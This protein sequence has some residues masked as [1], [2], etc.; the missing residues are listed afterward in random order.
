[1]QQNDL[2]NLIP[3]KI[4]SM[5][6]VNITSNNTSVTKDR[7]CFSIIIKTEGKTVYISDNKKY[8][9]DPN[10]IVFIPKGSSYKWSCIERGECIIIDFDSNTTCEN[11]KIQSFSIKNCSEF[12]KAFKKAE[13][14]WLFKKGAYQH[15]CLAAL[16]KILAIIINYT[17]TSYTNSSKYEKIAESIEFIKNNFN[18]PSLNNDTLASI[19]NVSIVYF[20]KLFTELFG[21]SPMHYLRYIR[22]K[23]SEELLSS[24]YN[25]SI[26]DIAHLVGFSNIYHFSKAFKEDIGMSPSTYRKKH[27]S[28]Y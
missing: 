10:H 2:S 6:R 19:S 3:S 25:S 12:I 15:I 14:A 16:N 4:L 27:N 22:I 28:P 13:T 23:K 21:M 5:L 18:D 17:D 7:K 26:A 1:M 8:I 20:R 9:S 11:F 24:D